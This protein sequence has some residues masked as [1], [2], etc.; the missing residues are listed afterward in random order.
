MQRFLDLKGN[1]YWHLKTNPVSKL[2]LQQSSVAVLAAQ[3]TA[4]PCLF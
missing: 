2:W 1:D 3:I 4:C